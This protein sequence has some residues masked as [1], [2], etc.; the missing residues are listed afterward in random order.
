MSNY[1]KSQHALPTTLV[2]SNTNTNAKYTGK[3]NLTAM[4]VKVSNACA[5][6]VYKMCSG[7]VSKPVTRL[8]T[9]M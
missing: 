6:N 7:H 9:Q 3:A 5:N 2:P 1:A 4:G 8:I